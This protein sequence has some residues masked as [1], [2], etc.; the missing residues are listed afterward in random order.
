M[1]G[2]MLAKLK[3]MN[4]PSRSLNRPIISVIRK[5]Y[6]KLRKNKGK[7]DSS[8]QGIS[9]EEIRMM[10]N[11]TYQPSYLVLKVHH[12]Q[13]VHLITKNY[14]ML[15]MPLSVDR[16][17]IIYLSVILFFFNFKKCFLI[18]RAT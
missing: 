16:T 1:L 10:G 5:K 13:G 3:A 15:C 12:L 4:A 17:G 2:K 8:L 18:Y 9:E 7:K 14:A 11:K 6:R